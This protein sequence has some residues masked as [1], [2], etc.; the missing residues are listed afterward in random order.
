MDGRKPYGFFSFI[1]RCWAH[2]LREAEV[3][4]LRARGK[5]EAEALLSSLRSLF[6][7]TKS[8]LMA[9]PPPNRRLRARMLRR[10]RAL[11]SKSY[12][13]VDVKRF[14]SKLKRASGDLFTFTLHPGV[15]PTNNHAERELREPI[16]HRKIR[17]QLKS[18]TGMTVFSRLMT[19][20]SKWK[21]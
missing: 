4:S 7:K 12:R 3:L 13:D 20:V 5:K 1:Q 8:G 16:V 14:V 11:L 6:H 17:G 18:E 9:H 19:A 15:Q 10:L 21:L 2:L